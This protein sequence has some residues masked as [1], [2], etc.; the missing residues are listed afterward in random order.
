MLKIVLSIALFAFV[1]S[2]GHAQSQ[3]NNIGELE[4]FLDPTCSTT[5]GAG[6]NAGG[7]GQNCRFC[8]FVNNILDIKLRE[9]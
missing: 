1:V 3:C 8:G 4:I 2:E 9:L 7:L 5:G 6:C